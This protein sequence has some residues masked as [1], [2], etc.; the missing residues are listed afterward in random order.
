MK[1][2]HI[3]SIAAASAAFATGA[4]A[5]NPTI[6]IT[7]SSAFRSAVIKAITDAMP[8]EVS[9][10]TGSGLSSGDQQLIIGTFPGI[11][12]TTT[13]RASWN[14]SVEGVKVLAG[15]DTVGFIPTSAATSSGTGT[16]YSGALENLPNGVVPAFAFSDVYQDST[17]VSTPVFDDT[18]VGVVAFRWVANEGATITNITTQIANQLIGSGKI[19]KQFFT[20]SAGDA[21][22]NVYL[23]GRYNG[24][25]TRASTLAEVGYGLFDA[26]RQYYVETSG[27]NGTINALRLW[28]STT[29]QNLGSIVKGTQ[30]TIVGNGGYTSGSGIRDVI[31]CTMS[32]TIAIWNSNR[33]SSSN[34][35]G[36]TLV[37]YLGVG[38]AAQGN[39]AGHV[40]LTYNGYD[41]TIDNVLNGKYTFWGVQHLLARFDTLTADEIAFYNALT[42]FKSSYPARGGIAQALDGLA[43]SAPG[44]RLELMT[45]TRTTVDGTLVIPGT[46]EEPTA[47]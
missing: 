24:S 18:F 29:S 17:G 26:V 23:T 39:A 2:S 30:D 32:G 38:D 11:T 33:T 31:G 41:Y 14:G 13:I 27:V 36:A 9:A 8:D 44:V 5:A 47:L 12:G 28:P 10:Y 21:A 42:G 34:D 46:Y 7:G 3:L 6:N 1:I 43:N 45:V 15:T 35:T 37:S 19:S 40:D 20:G 25:G 4:Y 22:K 16:L